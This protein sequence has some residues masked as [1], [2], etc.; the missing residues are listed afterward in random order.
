M[1]N[2]IT[3]VFKLIYYH[4]YLF[5]SKIWKDSTPDFTAR[6]GISASQ[7]FFLFGIINLV[8]NTIFCIKFG[9][10]LMLSL[11]LG[12]F[13]L[14]TL[15]FFKQSEVIKILREKPLFFESRQ[16]SIIISWIFFFFSISILFWLPIVM[17]YLSHSFGC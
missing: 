10:W 3:R 8:S 7:T 1:N 5:Y 9:K 13:L 16:I 17:D 14:N 15:V 4:Y 11:G 2:L 6:L 12:I